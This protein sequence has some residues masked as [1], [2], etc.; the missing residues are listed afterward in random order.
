MIV[1]RKSLARRTFLRGLG[2]TLAL[3]ILDAMTPAFAAPAGAKPVRTAFVYIP[4]GAI[5]DRW[6]PAAEGGGFEFTPTL[7]PLEPLREHINVI[8]GLAQING[9]ALGDGAGDHARAGA[10][11]LTGVHPKKSEVDIHAG[12]SADQIAARELGKSTQLASLELGLESPFLAGDCDSGYSCAYTNTISW[13]TPTTPMPVEVNPR[14]VFERLFGDGEST[15]PAVRLAAMKEQSS[16]LDYIRGDVSRLSPGLGARD[17]N[18]LDQYLEAIRDIERRI[19]KAEQQNA[20][21]QMPVME[22]PT[23]IPEDFEEHARLMTD[24]MVLAFQADMTRV[25]SFMFAREGSNRPYRPIGVSDG[26]HSCTH[27]MNDPEKI[28]KVAKINAYHVKNFA[29]VVEKFRS[30]PDGDGSLLDHSQILYG[31]SISDGNAHTHHD[32]PLVLAG[33]AAGQ[34]KGGR[35]IR[36]PKETPMNNLL[37][38]MLAQAGV[39]AEKLGDSTGEIPSIEAL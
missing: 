17:R 21:I 27:H 5:M 25:V 18:K 29:Y 11:W 8:S 37:L 13:R 6:T 4:N 23:G 36:F 24:L 3:P 34:V 19:Q 38:T 30:T 31:S 10:T 26:H 39:R 16:I 1:T 33:G 2:T 7:K 32:L 14:A 22:R 20:S 9:R 28:E 35:H 15:D 12:V